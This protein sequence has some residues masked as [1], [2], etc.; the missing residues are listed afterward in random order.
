MSVETRLALSRV[1]AEPDVARLYRYR[2][3]Y[4]PPVFEILRRLIVEPHTILDAGCGTGAL[5]RH[6]TEL[7]SRVDAVDPSE[8]MIEEGRRLL[9]GGDPRIRWIVGPAETAPLEPPYGLITT[10]QSLHWMDHGVVM[11]R[12]HDAL[13]PGGR[14]AALDIEWEYPP[15]WRD[16]LISIFERFSSRGPKAF[17]DIFED[18]QRR[19]LFE[20]HGFQRTSTVPFEQSIEDFIHALQS[21]SSLSRVTLGERTAAFAAEVRALFASLGVDR[22]AFPVAGSVVWGRPLRP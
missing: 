12:F 7:A 4:P 18:L 14:L 21:T 13:A 6:L 15:A 1:W 20:R 9:G 2:A 16:K 5:T 19:G 11:R 17:L 22:V 3:P 8:A 10:G